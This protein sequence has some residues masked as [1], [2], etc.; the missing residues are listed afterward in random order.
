[1][2]WVEAEPGMNLFASHSDFVNKTIEMRLK[3]YKK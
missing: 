3:P 2:A 1:V